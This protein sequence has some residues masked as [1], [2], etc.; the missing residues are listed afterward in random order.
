[1][2]KFK[3]LFLITALV[4][5]LAVVPLVLVS[6]NPDMMEEI[7]FSQFPGINEAGKE[8]LELFHF[9]FGIIAVSLLVALLISVNIKIKES[10]KTAAIILLV[11]H[12]G[13]V[14]PDWINLFVGSAH[15]PIIVMIFNSISIITLSYAW[16]KG[17]I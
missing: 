15:P 12:L 7:V 3:T 6:I 16:K 10:A 1:M 4:D 13:W 2:K 14:I 9:V 8:A 5:L 11:I 17:E